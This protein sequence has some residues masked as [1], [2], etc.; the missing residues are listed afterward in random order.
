MPENTMDYVKKF[1]CFICIIIWIIVA[2]MPE[3]T[4]NY[5][6]KHFVQ[7]AKLWQDIC[8]III[9]WKLPHGIHTKIFY[10]FSSKKKT[11]TICL[12]NWIFKINRYCFMYPK[13]LFCTEKKCENW[14]ENKKK[15]ATEKND[16][17]STVNICISQNGNAMH[18]RAYAYVNMI[19]IWI[20]LKTDV[21]ISKYFDRIDMKFWSWINGIVKTF[22]DN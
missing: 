12:G 11:G 2:W 6:R 4:M 20:T 16:T 17:A 21:D 3:N 5:E 13:T 1:F 18:E 22:I 19:C 15:C 14:C 8:L 10:L 9:Q 7:W